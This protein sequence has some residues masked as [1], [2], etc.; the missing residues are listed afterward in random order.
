MTSRT[1]TTTAIILSLAAAGAPAANARPADNFPPSHQSPAAVYS[2]PDRS[3]TPD[4]RD[5][6]W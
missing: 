2:R 3:M 4:I 6:G 1:A 5:S